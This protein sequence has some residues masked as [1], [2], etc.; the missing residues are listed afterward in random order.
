MPGVEAALLRWFAREGRDLPWRRTRDPYRV[1]VS[2]AILQQT[3]V[4]T[5]RLHYAAFLRRFPTVRA[6]AAAPLDAVM[7][8][9]AGMGYYARARHLHAAAREIAA[10]G[11][12]PRTAEALG[13]LPGLGRYAAA[14]VASF[15]FGERVLAVDGNIERVLARL[16]G[17]PGIRGS[18]ALRRALQARTTGWPPPGRSREWNLALMDAGAT[19]CTPRAP[20]CPRCPLRRACRARRE[21]RPEAYPERPPRRRKPAWTIGVALIE[22]PRGILVA[23]RPPRGSLGGLWELP[24]G[25]RKPGEGIAACVRREV[26]E[27]IGLDVEV[28]PRV[29]I[30]RHE[31]THARL[32]L[33]VF[34]CRARAGIP[35][36]LGSTAVRWVR[37][38]SLGRYPFPAVNAR[39]FAAAGLVPGR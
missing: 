38:S 26:R 35:R 18:A 14:A 10:A 33:H 17:L 34:R 24:G 23:R 2:E 13:A 31:Y 36:P 12:F 29:G 11:R 32:A 7:R 30:F 19:V 8:A 25:K 6:L 27:E 39:I 9:W 21:G 28:G 15:A 5:G 4:E 1:L 3:R 22:G 37:P 16:F 20:A